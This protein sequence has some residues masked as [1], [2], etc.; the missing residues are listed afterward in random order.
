MVGRS[1]YVSNCVKHTGIILDN[2][3]NSKEELL[4]GREED[5]GSVMIKLSSSLTRKGAIIFSCI[6]AFLSHT[7]LY[8]D[9]I[10]AGLQEKGAKIGEDELVSY[11]NC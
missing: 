5:G 11:S 8:T 4:L 9:C 2:H 6:A 1:N 3:T 7:I 10:P